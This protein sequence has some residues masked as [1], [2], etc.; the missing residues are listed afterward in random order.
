MTVRDVLEIIEAV[1]HV[2]DEYRDDPGAYCPPWAVVPGT[3]EDRKNACTMAQRLR[4]QLSISIDWR[5]AMI[6]EDVCLKP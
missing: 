3:W 1:E 6:D 4:M 5:A 2:E